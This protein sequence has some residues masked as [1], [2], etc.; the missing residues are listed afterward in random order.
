[1]GSVTPLASMFKR[2]AITQTSRQLSTAPISSNILWNIKMISSWTLPAPPK[3]WKKDKCLVG[4]I[5]LKPTQKPP[6]WAPAMLLVHFLPKTPSSQ[7]PSNGERCGEV[8]STLPCRC[9]AESRQ[10]LSS[11]FE[12]GVVTTVCCPG[13]AFLVIFVIF[14]P[15]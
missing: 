7:L 8:G 4:F 2:R 13:F 12:G 11:A 3:R 9:H 1:M 15:S 6:F 14:W 5:Y 10:G